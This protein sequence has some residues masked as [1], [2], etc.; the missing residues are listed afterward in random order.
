MC[1][2]EHII[3]IILELCPGGDLFDR[4]QREPSGRLP[5]AKARNY[6]I[7]LL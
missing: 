2:D 3:Y 4:V 6:F 5:E 7:Q 1:E